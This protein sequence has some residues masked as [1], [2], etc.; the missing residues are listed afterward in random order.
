MGMPETTGFTSRIV[1]V[2]GKDTRATRSETMIKA[3]TEVQIVKAPT[4]F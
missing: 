1:C 4:R 2:L 3:I